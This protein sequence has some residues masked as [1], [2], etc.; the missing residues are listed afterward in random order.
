MLHIAI[1]LLA[2]T[3]V[4]SCSMDTGYHDAESGNPVKGNQILISGIVADEANIPLEGVLVQF[5]EYSGDIPRHVP[6]YSA[7]AYT[8]R[9]GY[10]TI[11]TEGLAGPMQCYINAEDPK[12][13]HESA[14][15]VILVTWTGPAFDEESGMFVV[16]DCN[17]IM[18]I[19][20]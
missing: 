6:A 14:S 16:N 11:Y 18:H 9:D 10:Y 8:D 1:L 15:K 17:F 3:A 13:L 12:G 5:V 20:Q 2:S 7:T 4:L 19:K